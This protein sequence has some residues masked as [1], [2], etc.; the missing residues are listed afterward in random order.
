MVPHHVYT[1]V[2]Q[3]PVYFVLY[4]DIDTM[5]RRFGKLD[6]HTNALMALNHHYRII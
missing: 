2:L 3:F 4:D 1:L 6:F 5:K